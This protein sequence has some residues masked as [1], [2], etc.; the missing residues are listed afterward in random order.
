MYYMGDDAIDFVPQLNGMIMSY[1]YAWVDY[2]QAAK[3]EN[4]FDP[5]IGS[6]NRSL[7]GLG[8]TKDSADVMVKKD[9]F[10]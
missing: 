6:Y 9:T 8:T 3:K 2:I 7:A 1:Q 10:L 5:L 4:K